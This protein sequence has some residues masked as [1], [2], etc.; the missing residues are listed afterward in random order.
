MY[1]INAILLRQKMV[2]CGYNSIIS[3]AKATNLSRDTISDVLAGKT[4]PQANV[5]YTIAKALNLS[6]GEAGQIFFAHV[7]A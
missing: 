6:S 7:V 2:A 5:M 3:L 1:R 4:K